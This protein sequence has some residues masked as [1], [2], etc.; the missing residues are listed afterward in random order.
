MSC[1]ELPQAWGDQG[2]GDGGA[3]PPKALVCRKLSVRGLGMQ[4]CMGQMFCIAQEAGLN[5]QDG[6][7]DPCVTFHHA[8]VRTLA[9][10]PAL[11]CQG[12][13]GYQ[14]QTATPDDCS[15][16]GVSGVDASIRQEGG[17]Y[18]LLAPFP[19]QG[20]EEHPLK[21]LSARNLRT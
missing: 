5:L 18:G 21:I 19:R 11:L 12:H 7:S 1:D 10:P 2:G 9:T 6:E 13:P 17:L 20:L 16:K 15:R 3:H 8:H 14:P 4:E